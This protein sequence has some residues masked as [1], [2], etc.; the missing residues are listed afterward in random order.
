MD[1][2]KYL[3]YD[4]SKIGTAEQPRFTYNPKNRSP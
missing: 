1:K 4:I 3:G 2:A